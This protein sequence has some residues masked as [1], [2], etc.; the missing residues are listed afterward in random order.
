MQVMLIPFICCHLHVSLNTPSLPTSP[1]PNLA[2]TCISN[3]SWTLQS[4]QEK[5]VDKTK[6]GNAPVVNNNHNQMP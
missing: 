3:F 6:I 1:P 5:M 2:H 4:F